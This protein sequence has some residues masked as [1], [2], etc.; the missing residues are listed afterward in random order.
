M[1]L[2]GKGTYWSSRLPA[3]HLGVRF[4]DAHD[5]LTHPGICRHINGIDIV[6]VFHAY[7]C[8]LPGRE[9]CG[10]LFYIPHRKKPG[11]LGDNLRVS[12]TRL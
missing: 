11:W 2:K 6:E 4:V 9:G 5:K 3:L 7:V 1:G 12:A 8:A 10:I